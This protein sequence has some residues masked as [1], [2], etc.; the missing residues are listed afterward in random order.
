MEL[1]HHS[2][3]QGQ[4]YFTSTQQAMREYWRNL[5]TEKKNFILCS[6]QQIRLRYS[7]KL[8]EGADMYKGREGYEICTEF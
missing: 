4:L 8:K 1:Y 6:V 5:Q 2:Y 3:T 7:N